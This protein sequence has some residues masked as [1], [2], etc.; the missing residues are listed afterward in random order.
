[1]M[2]K[3]L[4]KKMDI[5]LIFLLSFFLFFV[6]GVEA[7]NVFPNHLGIGRLSFR[8]G[9]IVTDVERNRLYDSRVN[10]P[11]RTTDSRPSKIKKAGQLLSCT[12]SNLSVQSGV[13]SQVVAVDDQFF[14]IIVG[15]VTPSVFLN[16]LGE[17]GNEPTSD[18]TDVILTDLGGLT[19]AT[20][21]SDGT[22][23]VP[24]G[25]SSGNYTL[26]Y[27]IC[28]PKGQATNCASATVSLEVFSFTPAPPPL[29]DTDHDGYENSTDLD[30]DNDG[31]LDTLECPIFI[32]NGDFAYNTSEWQ[33]DSTWVW[34]GGAAVNT[35]D[36]SSGIALYQDLSIPNQPLKLTLKIG[37]QDKDD[38][39]GNT[40]ELKVILNGIVYATIHNSADRLASN[41]NVNITM[42]N[43]A[44]SDFVPF[45][46]GNNLGYT[47]QIFTINIPSL[48]TP[49]SPP[50]SRL[51]FRI[52]SGN[53]DWSID[54]VSFCDI[55]G[56][57]LPNH[58][59]NDSDGDGCVDAIEGAGTINFSQLDAD[60]RILGGID[61]NGVPQL[62]NGGQAVGDSQNKTVTDCT[63]VDSDG[64]GV[65]DWLD[66][67]DDNDGI[68]DMEE[69]TPKTVSLDNL[70]L[71][72]DPSIKEN[73]L[74]G[75][76][77]INRNVATL[78]GINYDAIITIMG[79]HYIGD[80]TPSN[81]NLGVSTTAST[82]GTFAI[83]NIKST[84]DSYF[85]Y[86]LE[87]VESGSVVNNSS[88]VN[89]RILQDIKIV[90]RDIDGRGSHPETDVVGFKTVNSPQ[91]IPGSKIGI[92]G[93][94]NSSGPSGYKFYRYSNYGIGNTPNVE[95]SNKDYWFTLAYN[96][97]TS[98]DYVYGFTGSYNRV[99][100]ERAAFID[101]VF[102]SSSCDTDGDGVP[103]S[104]DLD[105]D[106]DGC[107]DAIEGS[108]SVRFNE[109]YP[110]TLPSSDPNYPYRGQIKVKADGFTHG[111]PSEIISNQFAAIGVPEL[112][113]NQSNNSS[114]NMGLSDNS[115]GS[116]D[117]GQLSASAYL[118]QIK[119]IECSRCFR[120]ANTTG[121]VESS[122]FGITALG[123]AGTDNGGWPQKIK[124]AY[125][126]LDAKTKGFVIN[127]L[128]F[129]SQERPI[130]IPDTSYVQGM[131]VYDTTNN[132]LR[133]YTG[134]SWKCFN[135]QTCDDFNQ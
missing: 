111:S 36:G 135:T 10:L 119:D 9:T 2:T 8:S 114:G 18:N 15:S 93:F 4:L 71:L 104:L 55:D 40:G 130:G 107:P 90:F 21:N 48:G 80:S 84:N 121:N 38:L 20:I 77:L 44:T 79:K 25:A 35:Q 72:R 49:T 39:G 68:L 42:E 113:N 60:S 120:P 129:D 45:T 16:D 101:V 14:S 125:M 118:N 46:T 28:S 133:I 81:L 122:K 95:P 24:I 94:V 117:V 102:A 89:P 51:M 70:V 1:M 105:S 32:K 12:T 41:N 69:C 109:V 43:G 63:S 91:E 75:D 3:F 128:A 131:M 50:N 5:K 97:F 52:D 92:G 87:F 56:D 17:D 67:D 6:N 22:I 98:E 23:N 53:D 13:S 76:K 96:S 124:G 99:T 57:G 88:V 11:N 66:L 47:Y 108:E 73:F 116:A 34:D 65:Q 33:G 74:V 7:K 86:K 106:N 62:V 123:R 31:I 19:G 61:T 82:Q 64:D 59:D 100:S 37:A 132:C 134:S 54:D 110:L 85:I 103:N 58:L 29:V 126:V 78:A 127:R 27:Q 112:V 115:D 26:T 83:K 30:D